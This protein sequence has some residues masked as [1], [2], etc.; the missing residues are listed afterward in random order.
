MATRINGFLGMLIGLSGVLALYIAELVL[1]VDS[2]A[3]LYILLIIVNGVGGFVFGVLYKR[4]RELSVLDSLTR[5]YNRNYF[6]PEFERQLSLARR[7]GFPVSIVIF[8]LDRFKQHNDAFGHLQGDALLKEVAG[9]LKANV[10][11][12]DT[13]ARFGGDE[14]VLLL[15]YAS[16]GEAVHLVERLKG[17]LVQAMPHNPVS[18]SAGIASFPQDGTSSRELL[19]HAD[20]ALYRAKEKRDTIFLYSDIMAKEA[21][22]ADAAR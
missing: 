12:S 18:L 8:D 17:S 11:Q 21:R 2:A 19:Q 6:F 1:G 9:V 10:R 15:P 5:V 3:L 22:P 7:H 14:F 13:L 4:V 16:A 20:L